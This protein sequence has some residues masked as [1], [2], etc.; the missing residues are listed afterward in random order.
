[1]SK[2]KPTITHADDWG[3]DRDRANAER[4]SQT[5]REREIIDLVSLGLSNKEVGRQLDLQEGTVKVHLHNR[6]TSTSSGA[7]L[8]KIANFG[9]LPARA[10]AS[11]DGSTE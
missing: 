8:Y 3:H 4:T 2:D 9:R 7:S 5:P 10:G 6:S 11:R 1:M